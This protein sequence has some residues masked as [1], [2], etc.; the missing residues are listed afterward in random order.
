MRSALYA[1]LSAEYPVYHGSYPGKVEGKPYLFLF[2]EAEVRTRLK[3]FTPFSV[4]VY[5]DAGDLCEL[6][7]ACEAVISLLN[8]QTLERV[9]DGSAFFVEY[10]G[11]GA[12]FVDDE[13]KAVA[14]QLR[15][16][17]PIFGRDFL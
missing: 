13:K 11:C 3:S 1:A 16:L 7:T 4:Y 6:D 9:S 17:V 12:D 8:K 5:V 2:M 10:S 15:F 14:R